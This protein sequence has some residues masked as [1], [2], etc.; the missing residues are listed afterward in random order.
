[1]SLNIKNRTSAEVKITNAIMQG[2][3]S[4]IIENHTIQLPEPQRSGTLTQQQ[5][6]ARQKADLILC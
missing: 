1:M 4:I 2:K 6:Y 5:S 3:K